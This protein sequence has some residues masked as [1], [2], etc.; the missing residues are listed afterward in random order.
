MTYARD[1]NIGHFCVCQSFETTWL[2]SGTEIM[3]LTGFTWFHIS[4][5][6]DIVAS[7]MAKTLAEAEATAEEEA[8]R[9]NAVYVPL[10]NTGDR[11]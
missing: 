2:D 7:G 10:S 3:T 9:L 8:R 11:S 1:E 6:G 4:Q 5:R